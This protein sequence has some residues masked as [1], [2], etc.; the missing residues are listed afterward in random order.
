MIQMLLCLFGCVSV[1]APWKLCV[2][3]FQP[4]VCFGIWLFFLYIYSFCFSKCFVSLHVFSQF[5][6]HWVLRATELMG[7]I[8]IFD[9]KATAKWVIAAVPS[10]NSFSKGSKKQQHISF[11]ISLKGHVPP[12]FISLFTCTYSNEFC[13]SGLALCLHCLFSDW[14]IC[15]IYTSLVSHFEYKCLSNKTIS[16]LWDERLT[17]EGRLVPNKLFTA[18]HQAIVFF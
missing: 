3:C 9:C 1:F 10:I 8:D 17:D 18:S 13:S 6:V 14:A 12:L 11:L 2:L 4:A 7:L 15:L 5:A 16:N